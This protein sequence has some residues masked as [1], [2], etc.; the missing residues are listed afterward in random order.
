MKINQ[1]TYL[2]NQFT[3]QHNLGEK[4]QWVLVFGSSELI[5][6]SMIF[7]KIR[8]FFPK[9]YIMGCSTSGEIYET[10]VNVNS[11]SI[12]AVQLEKSEIFFQSY[13]LNQNPNQKDFYETGKHIMDGIQKEDLK[14]IF[15][16]SEG[17]NI[18]GSR[19]VEG[20]KSIPQDIP[21]T[22]GLAGDGTDFKETFILCNDYGKPNQ[23][24]IAA[25][26][27]KLRTGY[28]SFGGWDT[29][30]I[31]RLVTKAKD[32]ILYEMDGKPALDLYKEYLGEKSKDLP[33]SALL[34]PLGV[35]GENSSESYVRT[36]LGINEEN[37]S[38]VF[39]G[40]IPVNSYCRLMK[41]NSNNLIA[42]SMK[43]A[44]FS[45]ETFQENQVELAIL[46][47]CVGRKLVL[48][49]RTEEEIEV[50]REVVGDKTAITGFYSYGEIAPYKK[51]SACGFHNQ[52]MTI[53]LLSEE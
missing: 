27:G 24:V 25:I 18:N 29:F 36:I 23:I 5:K 49:Q 13:D 16:L 40:D 20:M 7:D 10:Q 12:T 8:E 11:L 33:A 28:A 15:I 46:V 3:G 31:E 43:A 42:G 1:M 48:K 39:A 47:S 37:K 4:A 51:D 45:S 21:I 50:V 2:E 26:Y 41:A 9:G 35:R 30:G 6:S 22:G 19:L 38:L 17:L 34:F 52:T 44:E 32:N 14:H 53:T